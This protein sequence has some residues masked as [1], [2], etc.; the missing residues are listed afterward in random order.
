VD[1]FGNVAVLKVTKERSIDP[2]FFKGDQP[3][4]T[5][6]FGG[7]YCIKNTCIHPLEHVSVDGE[8][9]GDQPSYFEPAVFNIF[10]NLKDNSLLL[11]EQ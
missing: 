5:P 10:N 8:I 7:D 3:Y 2:G 1:V 9:F 6:E 4:C 11:V